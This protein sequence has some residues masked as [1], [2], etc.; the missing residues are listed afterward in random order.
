MSTRRSLVLAPCAALALLLAIAPAAQAQYYAP[1]D[2]WR[3]QRHYE[4]EM[5]ERARWEEERRERAWREHEWREHEWRERHQVYVPVPAPYYQ[6][7][8]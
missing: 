3:A 6:P 2:D 5:R 4:H 8:W 7:G 1:V